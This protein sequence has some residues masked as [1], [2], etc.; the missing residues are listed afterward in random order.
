M[1]QSISWI[2]RDGYSVKFW[3]DPWIP[4]IGPLSDHC[5]SIPESVWNLNVSTY[6]S[7]NGWHW[8]RI[9]QAVPTHICTKLGS[10]NPSQPG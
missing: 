10:V 2:I 8:D 3:Q 7:I 6:A 5:S 1:I 4:G 9:E